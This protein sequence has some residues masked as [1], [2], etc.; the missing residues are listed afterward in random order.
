MA[1]GETDAAEPEWRR[2]NRANWDE[3]A[4]VHLGPR[5]YNLTA[6][7]A[8]RGRLGLVE[9]E[10][11]PVDGLKILHL[12]CH[13]GTDSLALAQ[14]GAQVVGVDFSPTAIGAARRLSAELGLADQTH[15]VQADVYEADRAVNDPHG[16]D[17]VFI[18]WGTICWIPDLKNWARI[19]A[20]FLRP[21]GYLY[22][23]EGHPAALVFDD[24][25]GADPARPGFFWPY[26][27]ARGPLIEADPRDYSD[28]EARL[29]NATTHQW[30]HPVGEVVTALIEAGLRLDWLHEHEAVPWRMFD[31]LVEDAE[32]FFRWPDRAWLPLAY[33]LRARAEEEEKIH[34][35]GAEARRRGGR[36]G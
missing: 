5:G 28:P 2:L 9:Q 18:T 20:H 23:A 13:I 25:T 29:A 1:G 24:Q 26:L 33:S 4:R 14:R 10:L 16:F 32:G 3:R 35:R 12:Q 17:R 22:F 34:H 21:C 7:R 19:I 30:L 27:L 36:L 6:L 31:C 15:F 8:G 11:G